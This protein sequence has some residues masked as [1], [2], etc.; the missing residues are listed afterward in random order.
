MRRP[1]SLVLVV[2]MAAVFLGA[3]LTHSAELYR[4][5]AVGIQGTRIDP[6]DAGQQD[7]D[8][9]EYILEITF[10]NG[11]EIRRLLNAGEE[12]QRVEVVRDG[13]TTTE[14]VFQDDLLESRAVR[15]DDGVLLNETRYSGGTLTE[16]WEYH[17][18]GS[19]L[20]SREVFDSADELL[21]RESYSYWRDD[22]LRSMVKE[23]QSEI[24]T[25]YR[26]ND[27]RL[28]EEW[29]SRPGESERFEFDGAGRLV[30]RELFAG[31]ELAEQEVRIYWGTESGSLLKLVVVSSGDEITRR[32]YDER[33]RL[34]SERR[35][36]SGDLISELVRTFG[37]EHLLLEVETDDG[38]T[39]RWEYEYTDEGDDERVTYYEDGQL[40][41]VRHLVIGPD[42]GRDDG[43]EGLQANRMTELFN[44]GEPVLRIY[45]D[46]Q[47]RLREE[48]IRNGEVIR[49]RE[50]GR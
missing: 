45:Y 20:S 6:D 22:T 49:T 12:V 1:V 3:P 18:D 39:R 7:P 16:R 24:R 15:R 17:Y 13:T 46:G 37:E 36:E 34:T 30:I 31:D 19:L 35:E 38:G 40:V 11:T 10:A 33:G 29:V 14:A 25:E 32:G 27:G 5:N 8:Q 50:F 48:V 42:D 41:E 26:Y 23:D 21:Y 43:R 4:S 47:L 44:R 9:T 2:S 28:E